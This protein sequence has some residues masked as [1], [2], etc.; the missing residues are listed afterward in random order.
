MTRELAHV[1]H[2]GTEGRDVNTLLPIPHSSSAH[3]HISTHTHTHQP[4]HTPTQCNLYAH[5]MQP[6]VRILTFLYMD[7]WGGVG[8]GVG[9][10]VGGWGGDEDGLTSAGP[11]C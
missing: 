7:V 4:I 2:P 5:T 1:N 9:M 10:R 6:L 11:R 8:M 3:M